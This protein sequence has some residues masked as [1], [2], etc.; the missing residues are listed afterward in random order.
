MKLRLILRT[1]VPDYNG[2]H[3]G[4]DYSTCDVE[5]P[6]DDP[7]FETHGKFKPEIIGGEWLEWKNE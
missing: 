3:T 4:Y 2:V 1:G 6:D 5:I 7:C